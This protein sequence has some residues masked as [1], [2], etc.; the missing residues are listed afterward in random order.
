MAFADFFQR[1][2]WKQEKHV[3]VIEAPDSAAKNE[4]VSINVSVGKEIEHP[5]TAAHHIEWIELYF[6]PQGENNPFHLG[7]F[8][9]LAHGASAQGADGGAVYAAPAITC[10]MK[11]ARPGEIYALAY[12]NI[13]G[14]W[15]SRKS[16]EV[17]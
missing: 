5:N 14:L 16:L 3:P 11:T 17:I 12:C 2:D 6:H 1:A 9:F 7:R 8:E 13:H 10:A 15:T 4:A